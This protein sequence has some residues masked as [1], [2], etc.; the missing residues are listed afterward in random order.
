MD[1][2]VWTFRNKVEKQALSS[3]HAV[4]QNSVQRPLRV[5][6]FETAN[7]RQLSSACTRW[8]GLQA[9]V[10]AGRARHLSD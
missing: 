2:I 7:I 1:F 9:Y 4:A 10:D 5:S 8:R 3:A 6:K